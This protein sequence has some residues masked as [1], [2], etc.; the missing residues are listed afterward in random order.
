MEQKKKVNDKSIIEQNKEKTK[1][2]NKLNYFITNLKFKN[3][4]V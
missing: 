2:I 1:Q 3:Y 4:E